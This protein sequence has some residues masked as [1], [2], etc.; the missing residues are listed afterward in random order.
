VGSS[1]K[2]TVELPI[3]NVHKAERQNR[4]PIQ[5]PACLG[6]FQPVSAEALIKVAY[7]H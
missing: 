7:S 2:H 3:A 4:V 1:P 6:L 5:G